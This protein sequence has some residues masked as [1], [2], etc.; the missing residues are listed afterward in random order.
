MGNALQI[1]GNFRVILVGFLRAFRF[2]FHCP[3]EPAISLRYNLVS[4]AFDPQHLAHL[5]AITQQ[6]LIE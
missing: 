3:Y 5:L 1:L 2:V 4:F 6:I